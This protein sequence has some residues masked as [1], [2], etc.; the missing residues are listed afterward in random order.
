VSRKLIALGAAAAVAAGAGVTYYIVTRPPGSLAVNSVEVR[1][2][3]TAGCN[4]TVDVV[5][6][7]NTNGGSG[8][9]RYR[10]LR[11]DGQS[12]K[13]LVVKIPERR[14]R[15]EVTLRWTFEGRGTLDAEAT[16][17][18]LE[19]VAKSAKGGFTYECK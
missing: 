6:V 11:S 1:P 7:I 9:V 18:V 8:D 14:K 2:P 13:A 19:P 16:L 3:A 10:W 15:T 5:G 12:S 4:S 17:E